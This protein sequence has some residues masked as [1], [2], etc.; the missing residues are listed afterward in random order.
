MSA[1]WQRPQTELLFPFDDKQN[2]SLEINIHTHKS[3]NRAY[4]QKYELL[5]TMLRPNV[6]SCKRLSLCL[7]SNDLR[8]HS[9]LKHKCQTIT[10]RLSLTIWVFDGSLPSTLVCILVRAVC[11]LGCEMIAFTFEA[12]I[13]AEG[14]AG[15][16]W[17][18]A[19][20]ID[21]VSNTSRWDL[22]RSSSPR[23]AFR[24]YAPCVA[25]KWP[26][27]SFFAVRSCLQRLTWHK[28]FSSEQP[29]LAAVILCLTQTSW[30]TS[31]AGRRNI[32]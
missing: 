32:L 1:H 29:V 25:R 21:L 16:M 18:E 6:S 15:R 23:C 26:L 5:D 30:L 10:V 12:L 2:M 13:L 20:V 9:S 4:L 7:S 14:S 27:I 24:L 3:E 19:V 22:E 8:L 28:E 31:L 11:T 17:S